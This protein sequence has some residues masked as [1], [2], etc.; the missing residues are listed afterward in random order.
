MMCS[1]KMPRQIITANNE[2]INFQYNSDNQRVLKTFDDQ[3]NVSST[4]YLHGM[5][6]YP[7]LE[8]NRVNSLP[9]NRVVYIYGLTGLLAMQKDGAVYYVLKDHLGSTRVLVDETGTAAAY[10]DY[11]PFGN[12]MRFDENVEVAYRFTGYPGKKR[13]PPCWQPG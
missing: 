7:L 12:L 9:E 13:Q 2:V 10:Y 5:N 4:L 1:V 3:A 11:A 8:K 6:D